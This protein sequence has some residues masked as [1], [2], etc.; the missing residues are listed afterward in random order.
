MRVALCLSG[1]PRF[2]EGYKGLE[3]LKKHIKL[4]EGSILEVFA[5][6][7]HDSNAR[8]ETRTSGWDP[9]TF[10][11]EKTSHHWIGWLYDNFNVRRILLREQKILKPAFWDPTRHENN[12]RWAWYGIHAANKLK[13]D[14]EKNQGFKYDAVIRS[15]TD[16]Y[17]DRD[18]NVVDLNMEE[19]NVPD[20]SAGW[21]GSV[22]VGSDERGLPIWQPRA[23]NDQLAISSSDNMNVLGELWNNSDLTISK[24]L[25]NLKITRGF[26]F[27]QVYS[28]EMMGRLFG[29][30]PELTS[31]GVTKH[32]MQNINNINIKTHP[33]QRYCN[34]IRYVDGNLITNDGEILE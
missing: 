1:L 14:Y 17:F 34:V 32:W 29:S 30:T 4:P 7:W 21:C 12:L 11:G 28:E 6:F 19:F 16:I 15:R 3:S 18:I 27:Y 2:P 9:G 8:K 25:W 5:H 10:D 13:S 20:N 26:K 31:E 24:L 33:F 22:C 23:V